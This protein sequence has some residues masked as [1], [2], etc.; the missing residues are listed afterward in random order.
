MG[1]FEESS[2][3]GFDSDREEGK[4]M[5][6]IKNTVVDRASKY[7]QRHAR[8]HDTIVQK[9]KS[10]SVRYPASAGRAL[11]SA[12]TWELVEQVARLMNK[13]AAMKEANAA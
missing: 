4:K 7:V 5:R 13:E 11:F 1:S 12:D 6:G 3:G 8:Y 10:Y 9:E 2:L